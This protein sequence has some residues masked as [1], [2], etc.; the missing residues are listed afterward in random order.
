MTAK[1][2]QEQGIMAAQ[3]GVKEEDDLL[4]GM[5][6]IISMQSTG[7]AGRLLLNLAGSKVEK[8][9]RSKVRQSKQRDG[10]D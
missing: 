2:R 7:T 6:A 5:H 3:Q 8:C 4:W 1:R 10:R 9:G